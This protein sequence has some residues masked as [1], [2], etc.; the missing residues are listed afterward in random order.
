MNI[1]SVYVLL[2][3]GYLIKQVLYVRRSKKYK[4]MCGQLNEYVHW[5]N[6]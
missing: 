1:I 5:W 3:T 6:T 4:K 2:L